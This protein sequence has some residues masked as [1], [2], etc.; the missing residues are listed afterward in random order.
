MNRAQIVMIVA[1]AQKILIFIQPTW[2]A[3][4]QLS[5]PDFWVMEMYLA[6]KADLMTRVDGLAFLT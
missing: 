5:P 3:Q 2:V 6:T 1:T 4:R